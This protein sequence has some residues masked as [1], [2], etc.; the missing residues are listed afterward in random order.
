M[1]HS[2]GEIRPVHLFDAT[3]FFLFSM[4]LNSL[5]ENKPSKDKSPITEEET[6]TITPMETSTT[7]MPWWAH[8]NKRRKRP[9][10]KPHK[11]PQPEA[12]KY[13]QEV[14]DHIRCYSYISSMTPLSLGRPNLLMRSFTIQWGLLMKILPGLLLISLIM[15]E[16]ETYSSDILRHSRF[17]RIA[18]L[19]IRLSWT[20]KVTYLLWLVSIPGMREI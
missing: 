3:F 18:T 8:I 10:P 1:C 13:S 2:T 11:S 4:T 16:I 19:F 9:S 5:Y 14:P 20:Q 7:K 15:A 12:V 6:G 17:Q